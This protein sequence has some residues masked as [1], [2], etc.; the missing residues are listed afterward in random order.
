MKL[1]RFISGN[2]VLKITSL[3]A[4]VISIR[5]VVSVIIQRILAVMLGEAGIASI[6]QIRN[7]MVMLTSTSTLGV[8]NGLVKYV[9]EFK[10]N[11]TEL[12]NVSVL[13]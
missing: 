11:K 6:G 3:N 7:L 2:T 4:V 8:F 12:S 13:G 10:E 9:S 5:L 1:P